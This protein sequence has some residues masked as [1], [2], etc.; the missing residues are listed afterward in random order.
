[1]RSVLNEIGQAVWV[2]KL[3]K[4]AAVLNVGDYESLYDRPRENLWSDPLDWIK[5]IHPDD[6]PE[7]EV[8]LPDQR[9]GNFDVKY[10]VVH[11]DGTIKWLRDRAF[12][13]R[14]EKGVEEYQAGIVT[15]ITDP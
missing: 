7:V 11:R 15:D 9:H 2:D 14:D 3:D 4:T 10:R 12:L 5:A 6:R 13:L 1:M 8:A